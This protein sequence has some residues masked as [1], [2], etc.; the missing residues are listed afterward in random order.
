MM[1]QAGRF[2]LRD[3]GG[4]GRFVRMCVY[5]LAVNDS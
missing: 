1:E 4:L 2:G 5:F 3:E